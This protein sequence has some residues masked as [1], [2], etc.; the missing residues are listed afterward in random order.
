VATSNTD[1]GLVAP[2]TSTQPCEPARSEPMTEQRRRAGPRNEVGQTHDILIVEDEPSVRE[3][4]CQTLRD[5]GHSVAEATDGEQAV[6]LLRPGHYRLLLLDLMMPGVD[7]FDVLRALRAEPAL[8][9]P[10]V[11]IV[12]ALRARRWVTPRAARLRQRF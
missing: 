12:S 3:L 1:K 6:T 11:L 8:R 4:L 7:G 5:E 9:P 2:S 10:A